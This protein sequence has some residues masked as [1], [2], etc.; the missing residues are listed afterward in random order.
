M[1][2]PI[3]GGRRRIDRVLAYDYLV[4]L[5]TMPLDEVRQRRADAE[6]EE[7]DLSFVRRLLQGRIDILRAELVR[8]R[9]PDVDDEDL[10]ARLATVLATER[11]A[12]HGLGR[13][14][15]AEPRVAEHRRTV[16]RL[17]ADVGISDPGSLDDGQLAH[18]IARLEEHELELSAT[19]RAVQAVMDTCAAEV[20]R[21]YREGSVRV[22]DVLPTQDH[23]PDG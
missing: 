5:G 3:P 18:A 12:P 17:V 16:E 23:G 7:A 21:R 14:V 15:T 2:Q 10:V 19:R 9:Q 13:H 22:E 8:R 1:T 6:Q 4:G 20:A 11:Q